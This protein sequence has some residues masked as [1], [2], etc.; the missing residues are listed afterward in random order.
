MPF[1]AGQIV[2]ASALNRI[3]PV[4]YFGVQSGNGGFQVVTTT[5]TDCKNC[6]VN[7]T[8]LTAAVCVVEAFFDFETSATGAAVLQGQL[9]VDGVTQSG[10]A[11]GEVQT[12]ER[13]T[14]GHSWRFVLSGA[15]AHVVKLQAAKT[16]ALGTCNVYDTHTEFT[17]TVYEIV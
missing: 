1:V 16:A 15:G 9:V 3:Q 8:S 12:I 14:P 5:P 11:H 13:A 6:V 4:P 2:R 17:L 10:E 7:F